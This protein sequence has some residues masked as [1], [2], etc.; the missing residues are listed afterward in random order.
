MHLDGTHT[1]QVPREQVWQAL[2]D[3]DTLARAVPGIKTLKPEG[4]DTY[5]A[6][7]EVKLGPVSGKFTGE[8][9]VADKQPPE[10]FLLR[11][12]QNSKMGNVAAEG[13]IDLK[14]IS[15][16]ETEVQFAGDAK[17]SG[18]LARMGQRV[19]GGVAKSLTKQFF[20]NLEEELE[21]EKEPDKE[22]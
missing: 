21:E 5:E 19:L 13:T 18:T 20:K 9:S 12:T 7:S 3:P 10:H 14:A 17:L 4:E 1:L 16:T 22:T 2:Q 6:I 8:M 15:E 11:M